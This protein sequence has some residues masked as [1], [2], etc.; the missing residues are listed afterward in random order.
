MEKK[1]Y[2]QM[3][4]CTNHFSSYNFMYGK[5]E[6]CMN[7]IVKHGVRKSVLYSLILCIQGSM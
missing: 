4:N 3:E 1:I 5:F 2:A 6:A 7:E